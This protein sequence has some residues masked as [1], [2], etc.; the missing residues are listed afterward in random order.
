MDDRLPGIE[1]ISFL[2]VPVDIL[3]EDQIDT[4][5]KQMSEDG[6]RHQIVLINFFDLMRA[7]RSK[8]FMKTLEDASLVLPTSGSILGGI[9][10]LKKPQAFRYRPFD[11]V[12]R[13]LGVMEKYNKTLYLIGGRQNS[14]QTV[15]NNMKIS[16]PGLNIV[17]RYT[18]Y[19]PP[20]VEE[21]ILTAIKKAS[22]ALLLAG[23]GLKGHDRWLN[24]HKAGFNPGI[25]I[26]CR[27]CFSIFSGKKKKGSRR[28]W[29]KGT[30]VIPEVLKNPFKIFRVFIRLYYL[31]LLLVYRISGK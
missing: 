10:F 30:E 4:V 2:K 15:F 11:F 22:P 7:R 1:R 23:D 13:I 28:S 25:Y 20:K 21:N 6:G 3:R 5:F 16:F 26:C 29:E 19:Y 8:D 12:I 31:F 24:G 9:K 27:E 18:G 17:G 14:L